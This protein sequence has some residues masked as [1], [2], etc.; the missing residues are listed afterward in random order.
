[1]HPPGDLESALP[2]A[3]ASAHS[4]NWNWDPLVLAQIG[5]FSLLYAIGLWRLASGL[6]PARRP[7]LRRAL[8]TLGGIAA[9]VLSLLSP[10]ALWSEELGSVHMVQHMLLMMVAA[11][12]IV[13]GM[14]MQISFWA[15]PAEWRRRVA[16]TWK[17]AGR[18][19]SPWYLLWQPVM[20]WAIYL[21]TLWG[22]HHPL[23]YEA[24]LR[25]QW[26]H[27]LQHLAFFLVSC[28]FWSVLLDPLRRLQMGRGAGILYLFTTSLHAAVLG[29]FMTLAPEIWYGEY[30]RTTQ[31]WGLTPLEDQQLAGLIMWMPACLA[32][33]VVTGIVFT[34][35]L[36][37]AGAGRPAGSASGSGG[38]D[39]GTRRPEDRPRPQEPL[40]SSLAER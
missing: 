37:E 3:G 38:E 4:L 13:L 26:V 36:R 7:Y 30:A 35:W 23:L 5:A 32:Y 18:W 16:E 27:Y 21:V 20:L 19:R 34:A 28:L 29:A 15:L 33:L 9:L 25:N 40:P 11:P 17:R 1:M 24:A 8:A 6:G 12:L 22:W 39:R 31:A 2:V 10:I 14:P